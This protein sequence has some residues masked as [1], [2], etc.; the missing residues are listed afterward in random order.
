M[1]PLIRLIANLLV[2]GVS[3]YIN[4]LKCSSFCWLA[5]G[6]LIWGKDIT[7]FFNFQ[8]NFW[9][10]IFGF[11]N[12]NWEGAFYPSLILRHILGCASSPTFLRWTFA[13]VRAWMGA[14]KK[15]RYCYRTFPLTNQNFKLWKLLF[16]VLQWAT[17][18]IALAKVRRFFEIPK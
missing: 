15:A 14:K 17:T 12:L 1:Q 2:K 8:K 6:G 3:L 9:F 18:L 11:L 5:I 16:E 13:R 4:V 7:F 10:L